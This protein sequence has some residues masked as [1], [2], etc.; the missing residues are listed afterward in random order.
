MRNP[1]ETVLAILAASFAMSDDDAKAASTYARFS[2]GAKA[3]PHLSKL[4]KN[5]DWRDYYAARWP[6]R[7]RE[8]LEHL[9][10]ALGKAGFPV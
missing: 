6:F 7:N 4:T 1:P 8:D 9:M 2:D 3:S 10:D 5:E